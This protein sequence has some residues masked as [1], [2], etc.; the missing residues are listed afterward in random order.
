MTCSLVQRCGVDCVLMRA[1]SMFFH[2]SDRKASGYYN[3]FD[4]TARLLL[5]GP[6]NVC[7]TNP[8]FGQFVVRCTSLSRIPMYGSLSST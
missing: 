7:D 6:P 4:T 8:E 1:R 2:E 5:S 3:S